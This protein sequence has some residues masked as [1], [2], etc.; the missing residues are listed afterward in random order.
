MVNK[1]WCDGRNIKML[2]CS[3]LPDLALLAIKCRP[4]YLPREFTSVI[5]T[6]VTILMMGR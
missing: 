3:C 4:H 5:I 1:N 6:A 2:S